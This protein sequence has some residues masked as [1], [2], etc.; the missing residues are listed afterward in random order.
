MGNLNSYA[1]ADALGSE[2][3][4]LGAILLWPDLLV[5]ASSRI[6]PAD[7]ALESHRTIFKL[8]VDRTARVEQIDRVSLSEALKH[9]GRL[10][11]IGGY[12][13]LEEISAP[14][15]TYKM[16]SGFIDSVVKASRLRNLTLTLERSM[17]RAGEHE[18]P[19]VVIGELEQ[20]LIDN[21]EHGSDS[22]RESLEIATQKAFEEIITIKRLAGECIGLVTG[23]AELDRETTGLRKG[24]Y[25]VIGAR[26]GQG[27]SWLMCQIAR[28]N[29]KRGVAVGIFSIEMR[30]RQ[31]LHRLACQESGVSFDRIRDPRYLNTVDENRLAKAYSEIS[32]WPLEI[33][34]T[35]SLRRDQLTSRARLM[36]RKGTELFL[37]DYL[38][39]IQSERGEKLFEAVTEHSL[40]IAGLAKSTNK[41]VVA[42]SQLKRNGDEE[43]TLEDLR[44]SGQIEQ[45]ADMVWLINR[46]REEGMW[47]RKDKIIIAKNRNGVDG[48]FIRTFFD[49]EHGTFKP[50][51]WL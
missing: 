5:Q 50:G 33:D 27:K 4:L 9:S 46:P 45:D 34:D 28:A 24:E 32:K 22:R 47:T 38:Q 25:T 51:E 13:Y 40:A 41:H 11:M 7:F 29:C 37:I 26:P 31:L 35:T 17:S 15:R 30:R 19:D 20:D 2:Q 42:L 3:A 8:M 48:Q 23:M 43:P 49:G 21:L 39:R 12:Q 18:D 14:G 44:Q 1:V 36:A 10:E 6:E 16:I